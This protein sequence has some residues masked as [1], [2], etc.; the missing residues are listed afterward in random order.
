M[1]PSNGSSSSSL[2]I[3]GMQPLTMASNSL[4]DDG[5]SPAG[6][7][8]K[9]DLRMPFCAAA[10]PASPAV[11]SSI[12]TPSAPDN[13]STSFE[14]IFPPAFLLSLP[15]KNTSVLLLDSFPQRH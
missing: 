15:R 8:Q 2:I 10:L 9:M 4:A 14:R 13:S 3:T 1:I 11:P 6:L 5:V 7:K 12:S